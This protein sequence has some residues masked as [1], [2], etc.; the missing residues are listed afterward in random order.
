MKPLERQVTKAIDLYRRTV[1]LI[2]FF[3]KD[4]MIPRFREELADLS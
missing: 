3:R 2:F 1:E 4:N